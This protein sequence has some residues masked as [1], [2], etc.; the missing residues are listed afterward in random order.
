ME[1]GQRRFDLVNIFRK[2]L[3][4][5]HVGLF[6]KSLTNG[7]E[8]RCLEFRHYF[9]FKTSIGDLIKYFASFSKSSNLFLTLLSKKNM[10]SKDF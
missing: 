5:K 3:A 9:L 7:T 2:G 4:E 1:R 10:V 8:K 6:I